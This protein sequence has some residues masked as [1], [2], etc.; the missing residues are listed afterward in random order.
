MGRIRYAKRE[1][2]GRLT[3][4]E[5]LEMNE[6]AGMPDGAAWALAEEMAGLETGDGVDHLEDDTP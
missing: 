4:R 5:A 1:R 6:A 3:F 2:P